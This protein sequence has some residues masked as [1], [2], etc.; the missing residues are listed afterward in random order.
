M[1]SRVPRPATKRRPPSWCRRRSRRGWDG[2]VAGDAGCPARRQIPRN[3]TRGPLSWS[4]SAPLTRR[5]TV[6]LDP[7]IPGGS[8]EKDTPMKAKSVLLASALAA[9]GV[10]G[11]STHPASAGCGVSITVDNDESTGVPS[12]GA[13]PGQDR[14]PRHPGDLGDA[15]ELIIERRCR[16]LVELGRAHAS[17]RPRLGLRP[18]PRVQDQRV[19]RLEQLVRVLPELERVDDRHH[20]VHP[21]GPL[22]RP[23]RPA[24]SREVRP[25]RLRRG[26]DQV[27]AKLSAALL[28]NS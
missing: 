7:P 16:Q 5:V 14:R 26:C 4:A 8:T 6:S 17:I 21:A 24:R 18:R 12:T 2:V 15:R 11:A 13:E 25:S 9:I 1:S 22:N 27:R 28:S 19:E 10:V 20:P 3:M 23:P